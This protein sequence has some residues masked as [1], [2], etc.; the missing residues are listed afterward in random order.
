MLTIV[1]AT[2][3]KNAIRVARHHKHADPLLGVR[4][5]E[6]IPPEVADD[7]DRTLRFTITTGAVDR[8]RDR[9][10]VAGWQFDAFRKNPVVL[11]AHDSRLLPLG[12][13]IDL[14]ASADRVSATVKFL[15]AEGF[16]EAGQ[17]ADTV[18]RMG[19][20]GWLSATSVGFRPLKWDFTDDKDRGADDWWPGIDFHEQELVEFSICT[21]PAN[22]EALIEPTVTAGGD[23]A[24]NQQARMMRER[25]AR[26]FELISRLPG[27][28]PLRVRV[29]RS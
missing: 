27:P 29:P 19:K 16:G 5:S 24:A 18:Y 6:T 26:R 25:R 28:A 13:A 9:I 21:V 10:N 15:P 17:F 22:P 1:S 12:K 20:D 8:D 4:K 23:D 2:G 3:F 7:G 11:W 14:A